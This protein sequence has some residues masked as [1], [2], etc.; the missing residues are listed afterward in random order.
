MK[1]LALIFMLLCVSVFS[2][3]KDSKKII[4]PTTSSP[5]YAEV[6]LRKVE[7]EASLEDLLTEFTNDSPK[8]KEV[9]YELEL[10][11]K[12]IEKIR[13]IN[14]NE[15]SKLTLALGKLIVRKVQIEVELWSLLQRY[16]QEYED[17]KRTRKKLTVF[18]NAIKEIL[19]Q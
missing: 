5:A 9:R 17:V 4:N 8:V 18:E 2:Q 15:A 13:T 14:P 19:D 7:L 6:L 10:I 16:T 1:S 3:V 11:N 12:E